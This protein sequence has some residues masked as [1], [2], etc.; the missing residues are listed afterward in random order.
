MKWEFHMTPEESGDVQDA[1][2]CWID[3]YSGVSYATEQM[4][5]MELLL[6]RLKVWRE[7]VVEQDRLIAEAQKGK[8]E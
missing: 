8:P 2:E 4:P 6:S 3:E 1:L 7:F 5:R